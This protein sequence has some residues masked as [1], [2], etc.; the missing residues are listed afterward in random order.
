MQPLHVFNGKQLSIAR[1]RELSACSGLV[2]LAPEAWE[3]VAAS[4]AIVERHMAAGATIYG[5]NTGIGRRCGVRRSRGLQ[6][7]DDRQRG[8]RLSGPAYF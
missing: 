3:R 5:T 1:I 8:Y 6:Q 4:R 2:D 7:Q